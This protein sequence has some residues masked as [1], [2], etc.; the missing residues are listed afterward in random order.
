[1]RYSSP[2]QS[3][4]SPP[5]IKARHRQAKIRAP[6]RRRIDLSCGC[7]IYRSINC[8]NH[9]FTHRGTH[10]CS[11]SAEWRIY[12][13]DTKSPIFQNPQPQQQAVQH[14][15]RHHRCPD[16]VQLQLN[17]EHILF[18]DFLIQTGYPQKLYSIHDALHLL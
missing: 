4:S 11:S 8:H 14:E 6:R 10:H 3:H 12:M 1:M 15:P 2:S 13:G 9:G 7:S 18:H 16:S 5:P 17:K